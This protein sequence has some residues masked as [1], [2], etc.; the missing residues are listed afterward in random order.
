[1]RIIRWRVHKNERGAICPQRFSVLRPNLLCV[2]ITMIWG[3]L[4]SFGAAPLSGQ[5]MWKLAIFAYIKGLAKN[6]KTGLFRLTATYWVERYPFFFSYRPFWVPIIPNIVA[7]FHI[8]RMHW[9]VITKLHVS[10]SA[11]CPE[12]PQNWS[13]NFKNANSLWLVMPIV[14]K[15][16]SIDS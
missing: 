2:I 15:L 6:H 10:S 16:V 11:P 12:G 14:I 4:Y 3:D 5:E 13:W 1:M 8:L 7:K 9:H